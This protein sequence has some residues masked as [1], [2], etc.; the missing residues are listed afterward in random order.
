LGTHRYLSNP[1]AR[2][3]KGRA[4]NIFTYRGFVCPKGV[5]KHFEQP[6][7]ALAAGS[8]KGINRRADADIDKTT[9]LMASATTNSQ[10]SARASATRA[11]ARS[12]ITGS[13]S[14]A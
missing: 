13:M 6:C 3:E 9:L 2:S 8:A 12:S 4:L 1:S 11:R 5:A 10:L 7:F 14:I